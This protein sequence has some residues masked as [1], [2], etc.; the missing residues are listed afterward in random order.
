MPVG[1]L[2]ATIHAIQLNNLERRVTLSREHPPLAERLVAGV[3]VL[4]DQPINEL[5]E[6]AA[7]LV[8]QAIEGQK[9]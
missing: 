6:G 8:K 4:D 2:E 5:L 7:Q 1:L 9:P 3:W